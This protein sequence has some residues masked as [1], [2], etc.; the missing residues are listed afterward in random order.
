MSH[1]HRFLVVVVLLLASACTNS[2]TE[3]RSDGATPS[4]GGTGGITSTP[5]SSGGSKAADPSSSSGGSAGATATTGGPSTSNGG[6]SGRTGGTGG[7]SRTAG[8]TSSGAG[9]TGGTSATAGATASIPTTSI[10]A[11]VEDDAGPDGPVL[12]QCSNDWGRSVFKVC[13]DDASA[14]TYRTLH[15]VGRVIAVD[16][17][18][19]DAGSQSVPCGN[20]EVSLVAPQGF[21]LALQDSGT[22]KIVYGTNLAGILPSLVAWMGQTVT[23]DVTPYFNVEYS[24]GAELTVSDNKGLVLALKYRMG[25]DLTSQAVGT[26]GITVSAGAAACVD[27]DVVG[28]TCRHVKREIVFAGTTTVSLLPKIPGSFKVGSLSFTGFSLGCSERQ[29]RCLDD[30]SWNSWAIWRDAP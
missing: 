6:T 12:A 18:A 7:T 20:S 4:T 8:V 23:V 16:T 17:S 28:D 5:V 24:A 15:Y 29:G 1:N 27:R 26:T 3:S 2:A 11:S 10:D 13:T 22:A 9:G 21:T 19:P 30:Y 14:L 25:S